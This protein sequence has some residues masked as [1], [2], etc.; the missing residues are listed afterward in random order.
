MDNQPSFDRSLRVPALIGVFSVL[1]IVIV[2]FIGRLTASRAPVSVTQTETPFKYIYLGTEPGISTE[3]SPEES[4]T[5]TLADEPPLIFTENPPIFLTPDLLLPTLST[6][7][8]SAIIPPNAALTPTSASA[9]P[10]NPG[11]YDDIDYRL[12]YSGEWTNQTNV[13]GAYQGTLHISN[14]L[15]TP[16]NSVLF[17]FIGLDARLFFQTGA[18][19]GVV[20]ISLD[21]K[22]S[23]LDQSNTSNEWLI[24]ADK[25]GTHTVTITHIRGGSVNLDFVIIPLGIT[26][27]PTSTG[28][29]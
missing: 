19:L 10:L 1:G 7:V 5:A 6:P 22:L 16:G 25:V 23:E 26:P 15:T 2:L 9:P 21:G 18:S 14:I 3:P 8:A 12:I 29:N 17:R 28:T 20:Q 11:T 27:S 24:T 13:S 4:A